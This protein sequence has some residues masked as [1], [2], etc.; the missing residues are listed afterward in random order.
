MSLSGS[1]VVALYA[2]LYPVIKRYISISWQRVILK[3]AIFFFLFPLPLLKEDFVIFICNLFPGIATKGADIQ[4]AGVLDLNYTINLESESVF[5]G[6]EVLL[7]GIFVCGMGIIT[8]VVIIRQ[9]KQYFALSQFYLSTAFS[10]TPS[11]SLMEQFKRTK[12]DF[13]IN[14]KV[15]FVCSPLCKAPVTIGAFSPMI[16]FPTEDIFRLESASYTYVL[17][18]ELLH[19]KNGDYLI[20]ILSLLVLALHWYNP[21]CY[22]LYREIC[23]VC[24]MNCDHEMIRES[25][26]TFRQIY[27]NLILDLATSNQFQNEKYVIGL[28]NGSLATFKRRILEMKT[29]RKHKP[30]LLGVI[31][32]TVCLVGSI[33]AFAYDA[34]QKMS[35][36][37]F[38]DNGEYVFS[39]PN[40]IE[41]I[42]PLQYDYFF[43]DE[44]GHIV[45]LNENNNK[46]TCNHQYVKGTVSKH[47]KN[48]NGGCVTTTMEAW[49]C[50]V[51]NFI[52]GGDVISKTEY[53]VCPH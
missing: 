18:H 46:I 3:A 34:P 39:F 11:S 41:H 26:E 47:V 6:S 37:G 24:E 8:S 28:V 23:G 48:S 20:K 14:R 1:V 7:V 52:Q 13:K 15:R 5:W 27:S 51:C 45:P 25:D 10:E 43:M 44:E 2:L 49:K 35:L 31:M 22:F 33:T 40:N 4:D 38:E 32:V 42:E 16:V 30:I 29:N 17:K 50:S 9:L 53:T 36:Q 12:E 19:I 21:V